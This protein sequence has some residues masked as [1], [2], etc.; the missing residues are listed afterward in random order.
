MDRPVG[1]DDRLRAGAHRPRA[2]LP[3]VDRERVRRRSGFR[4]PVP[5]DGRPGRADRGALHDQPAE[6]RLHRARGAARVRRR[7]EAADTTKARRGGGPER[8]RRGAPR[9]RAAVT[10]VRRWLPLLALAAAGAALWADE[11]S[12]DDKLRLLY[13]H[14]F[15]FTR[16]GL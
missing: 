16:A 2:A 7:A 15:T 6:P 5:G 13:S 4:L 11:M 9:Q 8:G 12:G 14:R 10:I 1:L 3:A